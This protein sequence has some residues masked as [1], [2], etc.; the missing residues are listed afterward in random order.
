MQR[1]DIIALAL[2]RCCGFA[3]L[4][5]QAGL[6]SLQADCLHLPL[7]SK[8]CD[9]LLSIAVLHHLSTAA[10]RSQAVYVQ[11]SF[12]QSNSVTLSY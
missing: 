1:S 4:C 5:A 8:S 7:R 6:N 11:C 10:R 12:I 9:A 3:G 2:D